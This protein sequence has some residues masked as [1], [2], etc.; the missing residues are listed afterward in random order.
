[1]SFEA[2]L[3]ATS[4]APIADVNEFAV[5]VMLAEKA[6]PDGCNTFPSRP[7]VA[8]RTR[9]DSR[10]VLRCLQRLEERSLIAKGDQRAAE[11]IRADRR[12]VVYD[13]LI[14]YSW[15]P[16]IERINKERQERGR[17]PLTP[18]DR[19]D[20]SAPP[21][22]VRRSD[23]GKKRS[24]SR[25]VSQS[26][27]KTNGQN[28]H[29]VSVS[30]PRGVSQSGA[31][32]LTDTR[33]SPLNQSEESLSPVGG[34]AGDTRG[35]AIE[36]EKPATPKNN[37]T[38][39]LPGQRA[40]DTAQQPQEAPQQPATAID[41]A[42]AFIEGLPGGIGHRDVPRLARLVAAAQADGWTLPALRQHLTTHVDATR[43]Y[44]HANLYERHLGNLPA[45]KATPAAP[46]V[47]QTAWWECARDT[48][49]RLSKDPRPD[50][51]VCAAC[52]AAEQTAQPVSTPDTDQ[53][54]CPGHKGEPCGRPVK[55]NGLCAR[56]GCVA[57]TKRLAAARRS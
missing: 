24:T 46:A 55:A 7:T 35:R 52:R 38:A 51:G 40:G 28:G 21:E 37:P 8:S 31:G 3:W 18:A 5:L 44:A 45:R 33:T 19:P 1:M 23:L 41:A 50:D 48:C 34:Q 20:I 56:C 22:K 43:V 32:C 9:V 30:P 17:A 4:D 25:G 47:E 14:P 27:R 10:T 26:P 36:R 39:P 53:P 15:F 12:P 16:N 54:T 2:V 13:L 6:D 29:G 42:A 57:D 49:N 11:Y